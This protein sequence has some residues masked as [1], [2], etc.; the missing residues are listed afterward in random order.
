MAT[1][2]LSQAAKRLR[3]HLGQQLIRQGAFAAAVGVSQ[4]HVSNL[5]RGRRRPTFETAARIQLETGGAV[6]LDMWAR[7]QEGASDAQR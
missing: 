2:S 4:S 5:L 6:T 7:G 3:E 1:E